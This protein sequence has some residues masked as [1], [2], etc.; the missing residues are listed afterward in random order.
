[1][2][3]KKKGEPR[4]RKSD[5]MAS[6]QYEVR[7]L[8]ALVKEFESGERYVR[9]MEEHRREIAAKDR[10]IESLKKQLG[11]AHRET[12]NVREMWIKTYDESEK[13]KEK[14]LEAKGREL[15]KAKE[16]MYKAQGELGQ[17]LDALHEKRL[18]L[19]AVQTRLEET[20]GKLRELT[21][22]LNRDYTNSSKPSSQTPSHKTIHNSREKTGRKPGGQPGHPHHGRKRMEPTRTVEIPPTPELLSSG[23][24]RPTG[25]TVRRQLIILRVEAEVVEYVTPE[26]VSKATGRKAHAPFPEGVKDDVNYDGTVKAAAYLLNN[27]CYVSVGKTKDFL[28]EISG[29]KIGLSGGMVCGLSRE[30]SEKTEEERN[31]IFLELISSPT[32][33]VDFTFGRVGGKQG[34]VMICQ[35]DGK[36]LYQ[37]KERK[38]HEGVKGSPLEVYQGTVVHDHEATFQSYG[39]RHQE[40]LAHVERYLRSSIENEP[41]LKWNVQMLDWVKE[42]VH[43]RNSLEGGTAEEE[44]VQ[45][46]VSR[47]DSII[48]KAKEEY[49]YEPP[50][51]YFKDGYNLYKRM[52]EDKENYLLF[53]RDTSVPPT[54]NAAEGSAR[55]YKR[56][57]AQAMGFRS[58][59]GNSYFCDGLSVMESLKASGG[60]LYDDVA[61]RFNR[62]AG[63]AS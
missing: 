63:A 59:E 28:R 41:E 37:G 54:N 3:L 10:E 49:E 5:Y 11:A 25:E 20:E 57:N 7:H 32:M 58:Q 16:E 39:G 27:E 4:M 29:G 44:K 1:M 9:I 8:R 17:A 52:S 24:Y 36:V 42:A 61:E 35:S 18:E 6:L 13:D 56:K 31:Q 12:A 60:D 38:G 15:R 33:H 46:L 30:F 53:L 55:K 43:Y 62:T 34:T 51:E 22:R 40:C 21:A 48:A 23:E 2:T 19:Y 47:Y 50:S 45:N 14:E 26:F